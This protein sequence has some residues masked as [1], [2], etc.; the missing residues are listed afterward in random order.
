MSFDEQV[1]SLIVRAAARVKLDYVVIGNA[2][3][4]L[5]DVP[6]LTQDI[7]MFLRHTPRN[8]QKIRALAAALGGVVSEPYAPASRMMRVVTPDVTAD[9]VFDLSSR[10]KF[11]SVRAA[12]VV[13]SVGTESVRVAALDDII[14]AKEAAG[15]AK[16]KATLPLLKAA[17]KTKRAL[18]R[19]ERG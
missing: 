7:D 6:I 16:D 8:V 9:F 18:E 12:A 17:L 19:H 15:R 5:H 14:R 1:L 4:A 13:L 11:E 10:R 2:G 3:A